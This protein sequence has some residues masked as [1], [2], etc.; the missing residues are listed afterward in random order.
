MCCLANSDNQARVRGKYFQRLPG[1][2]R[3]GIGRCFQMQSQERA[4]GE[5]ARGEAVVFSERGKP[6]MCSVVMY[7][8]VDS[9]SDQYIGVEQLVH[10][11]SSSASARRTAS[12]VMGFLP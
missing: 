4:L 6:A 10:D 2:M 3:T 9:K 5:N 1:G 8:G 11:P 7:V 12:T